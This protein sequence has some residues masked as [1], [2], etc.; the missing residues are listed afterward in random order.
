M[1]GEVSEWLMVRSRKAASAFAERGFKS[2][3]SAISYRIS[4][5]ISLRRGAGVA[6]QARRESVCSASYRGFESHPLRF[7]ASQ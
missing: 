2:R 1:W 3:L 4:L 6:E 5:P 7:L